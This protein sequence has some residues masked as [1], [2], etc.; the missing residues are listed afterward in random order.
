MYYSWE[1]CP[2]DFVTDCSSSS[3]VFLFHKYH[4]LLLFDI[5]SEDGG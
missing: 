5:G 4:R 2:K 3:L 1:K